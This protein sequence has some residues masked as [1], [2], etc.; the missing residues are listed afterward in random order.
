MKASRKVFAVLSVALPLMLVASMTAHAEGSCP[1][2]DAQIKKCKDAGK[3]YS[4]YLNSSMCKEA[5]CTEWGGSTSSSSSVNCPNV[6]EMMRYCVEK[7]LAYTK[8]WENGCDRLKC[9]EPWEGWNAKSSSSWSSSWSS[10]WSGSSSSWSS[11]WA[12]T[13]SSVICKRTQVEKFWLF[14]C[15][16]GKSFRLPVAPRQEKP[17]PLPMAPKGPCTDVE[18]AIIEVKAAIE[19]NPTSVELQKKLNELTAKY[20]TCKSQSSSTSS[21][22]TNTTGCKTEVIDNCK[23]TRCPGGRAFK[24]CS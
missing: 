18:R 4:I 10:K 13:S 23:V 15:E 8:Y 16:D 20:N 19:K 7:N 24:V 2:V 3:S 9:R 12:S 1:D 6:E 11:S 14:S 17:K 21:A 5:K 22:T